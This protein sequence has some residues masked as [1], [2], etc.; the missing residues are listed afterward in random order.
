MYSLENTNNKNGLLLSANK[1][2]EEDVINEFDFVQLED[3]WEQNKP[4][5]QN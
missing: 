5:F 1:H 3:L 2:L 4:Q